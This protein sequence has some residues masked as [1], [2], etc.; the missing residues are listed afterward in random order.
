MRAAGLVA[1]RFYGLGRKHAERSVAGRFF[2]MAKQY[3]GHIANPKWR[4]DFV[5]TRYRESIA[6]GYV[7]SSPERLAEC[8]TAERPPDSGPERVAGWFLAKRTTGWIAKWPAGY[9]GSGRGR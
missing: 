6:N 7:G 2:H 5:A 8:N 1:E 4:I 3:A 9:D